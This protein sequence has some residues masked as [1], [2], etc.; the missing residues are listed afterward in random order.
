MAD[1]RPRVAA[2]LVVVGIATTS[3]VRAGSEH[4]PPERALAASREAVDRLIAT[5]AAT[6]PAWA[7]EESQHEITATLGSFLTR[8]IG[9]PIGVT[10]TAAA[11]P[12]AAR[13]VPRRRRWPAT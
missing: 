7:M 3:R 1:Y 2:L 6:G 9:S 11:C 8:T 13:T 10:L 4:E 12:T 5:V